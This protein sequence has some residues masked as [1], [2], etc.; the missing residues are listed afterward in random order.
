MKWT[1]DYKLL[2]HGW[3][4][5]QADAIEFIHMAFTIAHTCDDLTDRDQTVETGT[6]QQAFWLALIDLP[7]NRFYVEHFALLNGALQ[8]AFLNWQVANRLEQMPEGNA[9]AVAF[10]LRSSYTDLVTLSAWILGGTDWSVQVGSESRLHASNE[11]FDLYA[12]R[13]T[14][15]RRTPY[16][17]GG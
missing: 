9:K 10:V 11:G 13:L 14:Q 12:F 5:G 1:D 6:M 15:E 16:V 2:M 17:L 4:K 3:L 8:T 7:R